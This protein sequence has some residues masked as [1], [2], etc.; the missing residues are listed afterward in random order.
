VKLYV[1]VVKLLLVATLFLLIPACDNS[2]FET[3]A[4]LTGGNPAIGKEK[5]T[6]YGCTAC[7]QIPGI[8]T[9]TG[10]VGPNLSNV[11]SRSYLAGQLPNTPSNMMLWIQ[12]PENLKPHT[13]MPDT[14]VSEGDARDITAFL[15]SLN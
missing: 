11:R 10:M 3:G 1:S 12:K 14:G 5:L 2:N 8:R 13:A 7:H 9:A 6:Y 4:R 15:Y